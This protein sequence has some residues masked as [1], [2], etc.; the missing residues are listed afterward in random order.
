M[1]SASAGIEDPG[2]R[3]ARRSTDELLA[4]RIEA[5][6][7]AA[8]IDWWLAQPLFATLPAAAADRA[9]RLTNTTE[10]LASSLRLAG[11]GS[12]EPL[13]ARLGE[14]TMPTL[15]VAGDLDAT[16]AEIGRRMTGL[17]GDNAELV[18]IPG[19][20]HACHLERLDAFCVV[21]ADFLIDGRH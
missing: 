5:E 8:F 13:W 2:Q 19:A 14:L 1:V 16:Y 11:A 6:G 21:L 15:V 4:K 7:V 9:G 20:G 12:Q 3:E 17:I 18:L 10:G